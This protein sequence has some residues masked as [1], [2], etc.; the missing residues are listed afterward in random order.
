MHRHA[1][2]IHLPITTTVI[3][4][5]MNGIRS[6]SPFSFQNVQKLNYGFRLAARSS[7]CQSEAAEAP[8]DVRVPK[9]RSRAKTYEFQGIR[10]PRYDCS[11]AVV[12]SVH[13][14]IHPPITI[15]NIKIQQSKQRQNYFQNTHFPRNPLGLF[16]CIIN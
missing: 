3:P 15:S 14:P 11:L 6:R 7:C 16:I 5:K 1:H 9:E 8:P 13:Q 12:L 2:V 4:W 10:D